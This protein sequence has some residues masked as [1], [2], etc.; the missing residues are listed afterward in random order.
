[1][2]FVAKALVSCRA[3]RESKAIPVLNLGCP[4]GRRFA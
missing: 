3:A 2:R 1:L 4:S